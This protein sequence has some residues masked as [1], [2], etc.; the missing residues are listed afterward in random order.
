MISRKKE[1]LKPISLYGLELEEAIQN[2]MVVDPRPLW[3]ELK[4]ERKRQLG[5]KENPNQVKM[6]EEVFRGNKAGRKQEE[7]KG[8]G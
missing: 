1:R 7:G 5:P 3:E 6:D 4:A 2:V 8:S